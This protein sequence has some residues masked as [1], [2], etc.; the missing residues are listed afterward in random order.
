MA[1][2]IHYRIVDGGQTTHFSLLSSAKKAAKRIAARTGSSVSI[3][4]LSH[5]KY[6][7]T[8]NSYVGN[9]AVVRHNPVAILKPGTKIAAKAVQVIKREGR[10]ILRIFK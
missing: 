1:K 3:D 2:N 6:H 5:K 9:A 7:K 4:K 10:T 8:G